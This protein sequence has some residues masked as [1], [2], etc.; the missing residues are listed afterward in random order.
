VGRHDDIDYLVMELVEGEMLA[1]RLA[2]GALPTADVLRL[3][4]QI[5]DALDRAHRAGVI[6][7]DLK[8]GNV[9]LTQAG[10]KLMDFGLARAT[11]ISAPQSSSSTTMEALTQSPTVAA[12]LTVEGSIVG[13]VQYMAPEQLE[14]RESDARSD[15]WALG[16]VLYEMASGRHAFEG[17]SPASLIATILKEQPRPLMEQ[18]PLTPPGFERLVNQCLAKNP[19]ERWQSA[20]DL[21]RELT[22]IAEH[23]SSSGPATPA[24]TA[25]RGLA[26]H[27]LPL[28]IAAA[29]VLAGSAY[30]LV[31]SGSLHLGAP[32]PTS[33][34]TPGVIRSIAVLPLDN[35]SGDPNQEYF[36]EG[37]TD[38]LTAQLATISQL[39]VIS[40]GSAMQFKGAQR[41]PTPEI[42]RVLNVD[43]I[44]EGSVTRVGDKVRITA[45]L[46]D[47]RAD[48]HLWA[49]SFERASGD[50]FA[51]QAELASA[52]AHA[53][54][55]QLTPTERLRLT[56]APRV[57]P[58]S[59]DAYL[60][61][62]YFFNRPSDEN[63]KKA[64]AQFE[65]AVQLSPDFAPAYSGLSDAYLWAGYNEGFLSASEARPKA[66][67]AAEKAVQ[68]DDNSAEAHTSLATFKL[69]YEYDWNGCEREFRRAIALNPSY[70][71]AHDQFGMA[72]A[73]QGRI[74]EAIAEGKRAAELDPLSPQVPIDAA[75]AFM[76]RGDYAAA[77]NLAKKSAEL[78]PTYFF[79]PM[80]EGWVDSEVGKA[81]D[82]I[83][84]FAKA[85]GM[86]SPAFVTAWLAYAYGASGDRGSAMPELEDLGK[87]SLRGQ[88]AP[89]SLALVY[90]R[91]GDHP[92]AMGYLEQAYA[93]DSQW[94]GWLKLDHVFDPLRSEPRFAALLRKLG[95]ER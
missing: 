3:G 20:S 24:R 40:R 8:P 37:M 68:L 64:I 94:L 59:H 44:V 18:A 35:Y 69:F 34:V 19:D 52:I 92:R 51:L 73:F 4:A 21:R 36:A 86:E 71:F 95:F 5:A 56:A 78:D 76:F 82:A 11:G 80:L 31:R 93:A 14:G 16:C 88:V 72:L 38:E 89:F 27:R 46:I 65:Q 13:T 55:V 67:G 17:T 63:L 41:P 25:V 74:D 26:A 29:V 30:L 62:R 32:A 1:Q 53:I 7:R 9:M 90:L 85:K 48:R 70:A 84:A 43:A 15:L 6:H 39:Q 60:K 87:K 49:R 75:I 23:G 33:A 28:W 91:L 10:A 22:W 47:A 2:K 57:D 12:P 61:G 77:K 81:G 66:K 45:Q 54:D 58:E 83:P 42:A 50:V 79:P